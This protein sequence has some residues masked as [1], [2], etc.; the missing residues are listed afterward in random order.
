MNW[1]DQLTNF[2]NDIITYDEIGNLLTIGENI[3]L[4]L[5]YFYEQVKSRGE[6]DYKLEKI[7]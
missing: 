7:G 3:S 6:W 1:K 5:N 4:S 2:N